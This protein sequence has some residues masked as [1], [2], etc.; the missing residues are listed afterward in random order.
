MSGFK[1]ILIGTLFFLLLNLSLTANPFLGD[2]E[3]PTSA[4]QSGG[5]LP[6]RLIET[7]LEFRRAIGDLFSRLSNEEESYGGLVVSLA[8]FA[9]LYG[10]I[11][12]LGPG[13]RKTVVFSLFLARKTGWGEPVLAGFLSALL[14]GFSAVGLVLAFK[15]LS[16]R[17]FLN[18]VN[19]GALYLEGFT[20]LLLALF[21]LILFL[22][23]L[24]HLKSAAGEEP[25]EA[26]LYSTVA[27]ASLFP[28]PAALMILTFS[29]TIER[30]SLG[31]IA[32]AAL[33]VGMGVV[34]SASGLLARL[35]REALFHLIKEKGKR[36][37]LMG[38][39]LELSAYL[40]L[41]LFSLWMA[42]PFLGNFL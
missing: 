37:R 15:S 40:F 7:Q 1:F 24:L 18:R 16:A 41:I 36:I 23:E 28:C 27:A 6:D 34:V 17:L 26:G 10:L 12:A 3:G 19:E 22:H 30:L 42:L 5:N 20:Y 4:R 35:G 13:H 29:L 38:S 33:S 8:G 9:F 31:I 14:H 2:G 25:G 39:L 32:V 11:H 21:A